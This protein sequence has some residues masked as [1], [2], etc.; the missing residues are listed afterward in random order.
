MIESDEL[1]EAV[2]LV[3]MAG[4][5]DALSS[6]VDDPLR[7]GVSLVTIE[8]L[9]HCVVDTHA[10]LDSEP[11]RDALGE[12]VGDAVDDD[13]RDGGADELTDTDVA[14]EREKELHGDALIERAADAEALVELRGDAD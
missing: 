11:D 12:R 9:A 2:A 5:E 13:D 8:P 4:E 10:V 14:A 1:L 7:V 6:G 3:V